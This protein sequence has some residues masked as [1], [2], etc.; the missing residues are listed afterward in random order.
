MYDG[1]GR[2]KNMKHELV[3]IDVGNSILL[4]RFSTRAARWAIAFA[5]RRFKHVGSSIPVPVLHRSSGP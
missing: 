2:Q 5:W 4:M 3:P 1:P